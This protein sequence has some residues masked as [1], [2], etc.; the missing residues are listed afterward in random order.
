MVKPWSRNSSPVITVTD[1]PTLVAVGRRLVGV[2]DDFGN[3]RCPG[4][5]RMRRAGD[6]D[7]ERQGREPAVAFTR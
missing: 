5:T 3:V 7:S 1:E 4:P 6:S 2:D